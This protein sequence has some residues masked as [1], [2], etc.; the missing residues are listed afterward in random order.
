MSQ[1]ILSSSSTLPERQFRTSLRAIQKLAKT[2][3]SQGGTPANMGARAHILLTVRDV[4][5]LEVSAPESASPASGS[6]QAALAI[7]KNSSNETFEM[8]L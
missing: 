2:V 7:Q 6:H 4:D 8:K 1:S 5:W 3:R